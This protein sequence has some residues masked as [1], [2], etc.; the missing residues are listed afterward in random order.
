MGAY[1]HRFTHVDPFEDTERVGT[2]VQRRALGNRFTHVDP[3]EDT[4][5]RGPDG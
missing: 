2:E 4:E 3:F 5:S 1:A